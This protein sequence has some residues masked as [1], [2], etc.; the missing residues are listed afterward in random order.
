MSTTFADVAVI[1]VGGRTGRALVSALS[2]AGVKVR[3][4]IHRDAQRELFPHLVDFE[5]VELGDRKS[6]TRGLHHVAAAYYIPP[7]YASSEEEFA[8]NVIE[9]AVQNN[10]LR[11]IYHSVLHS[12]TLGMPHHVRKS[13]VELALRESPL[14]WTIVQPAMYMQTPLAFLN[15]RRDELNPGFD[16]NQPF[17][18]IDLGDL[19]DAITDIV[20]KHGHEFAT[21]DLAGSENANVCEHGGRYF[22]GARPNGSRTLSTCATFRRHARRLE[23]L[24]SFSACGTASDAGL[25][26]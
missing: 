11:L 10:L 18:P 9:A 7:V 4:L 6:L 16:A 5:L 24:W 21:Y 20:I 25:L 14:A 12:A 17:T 19:A 13:R 8:V 26:Q 22:R 23:R 2:C 3:A 1:G 15:D